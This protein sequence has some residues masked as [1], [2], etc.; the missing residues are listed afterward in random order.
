MPEPA[1]KA[2]TLVG[3]ALP[4]ALQALLTP[5][6][7]P[8]STA[9]IELRETHVSWVI[10]TG[11]CAYK[12]KKPLK[13]DFID[14]STLERRRH[15]CEEE[16]RL[17]RRFA[18]ELYLDVVAV[19]ASAGGAKIGGDGAVIDYAVRMQ[20]F[21]AADELPSLL[22]RDAIHPQQM[23]ALGEL[24]ASLHLKAEMAP[25][26]GAPERTDKL[27]Q[28]VFGNLAQLLVHLNGV[29]ASPRLNSLIDWTHDTAQALEPVFRSREQAGFVRECHGDLHAANIVRL[30]ERLVPFDCIEFNPDLRRN[31]VIDD[32]DILVMDLVSPERSDLAL[33]LLSRYLEVTGDYEGLRV[34]PFCAVYRALVRAKIDA[35]TI[36]TVPGRADEFRKR[37]QQRIRAAAHWTRREKPV[38]I[39]MHGAS[40]SGKSWMSTRLVPELQ[41]V[42]FRWDLERKRLVGLDAHRAAPAAV[43]EGIYAPE[44]SHRTYARLAECAGHCL[45]AGLNTI[46]DAS[47]LDPTDR[48]TFRSLARRMGVPCYIVSC[49]ADPLTLAQRLEERSATGA[50]PSDANLSVLD[51]QLREF[52]PFETAER[53]SVIAV[54]TGEPNSVQW[55]ANDVRARLAH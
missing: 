7:Y 17:N 27:F 38:L 46:V 54:D 5:A 23:S 20:Q 39:L 33:A 50:D 24:L 15:L 44:V 19:T 49:Q 48:M 4:P 9:T 10:L 55:V 40:G 29:D 25:R 45:N 36:E 41:A 12:V 18:P 34:L 52:A 32:I 26:Q 51:A 53:S 37:L 43:R 6:A 31:D 30:G 47:F 2:V 28:A 35:L 8:H 3:S 16:L 22:A 42:R 11:S 13:L 21:S 14:A 1:L